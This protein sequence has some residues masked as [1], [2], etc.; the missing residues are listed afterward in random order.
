MKVLVTGAGGFLGRSIAA[1]LAADRAI[2]LRC[3]V[4]Q[5][6]SAAALAAVL[7]DGAPVEIV[8]ANLLTAADAQRILTGIDVLIHAAAGMRGALHDADLRDREKGWMNRA[9]A[10]G[11]CL[12]FAVERKGS[13]IGQVL[14]HD[15]DR[16]RREALAGYHLFHEADRGQ[17][18][19]T[20]ALRGLADYTFGELG[21]PES[22]AFAAS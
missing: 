12:F 13:L 18:L 2:S 15:I 7:P 17:G 6:K 4:R 22:W 21:L 1:R 16:P 5:P 8:S 11:S 20:A 9:E 19:G 14:L 10:D 3:Q